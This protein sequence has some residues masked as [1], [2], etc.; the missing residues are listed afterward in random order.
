MQP[1]YLFPSGCTLT[2]VGQKGHTRYVPC[3]P[4]RCSTSSSS[5]AL[6][7]SPTHHCPSPDLST[8]VLSLGQ[9]TQRPVSK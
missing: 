1:N 2:S 8:P 7:P 3:H 9:G 5:L 6:H 4:S